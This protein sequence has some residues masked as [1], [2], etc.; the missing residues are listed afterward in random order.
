MQIYF[1]LKQHDE[2]I[3]NIN[4]SFRRIKSSLWS[5]QPL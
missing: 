5:V 1:K 2:Y 3:S 4:T